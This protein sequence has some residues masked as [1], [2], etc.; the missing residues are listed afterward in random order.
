[1]NKI[2]KSIQKNKRINNI[3]K[4]I[5]NKIIIVLFVWCLILTMLFTT[6]L[7]STVENNAAIISLENDIESLEYDIRSVK[8]RAYDLEW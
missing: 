7:F 2:I 3:I 8:G 5:Q 4:V 1:M 6:I